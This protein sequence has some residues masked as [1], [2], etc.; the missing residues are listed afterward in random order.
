MF[1]YQSFETVYDV[2]Y[3]NDKPRWFHQG[4]EHWKGT[5]YTPIPSHK[6]TNSTRTRREPV[7]G[8]PVKWIIF[9][10]KFNNWHTKSTGAEDYLNKRNQ[11]YFTS[12]PPEKNWTYQLVQILHKK[13]RKS[14][15]KFYFA[16]TEQLSF[17]INQTNKLSQDPISM[18]TI[19]SKVTKGACYSPYFVKHNWAS[20]RQN[21]IE[22]KLILWNGS[23]MKIRSK[24]HVHAPM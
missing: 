22:H 15:Y 5:N 14:W 9:L 1:V 3:F 17:T 19:L 10:T 20:L 6:S 12:N 24:E 2:H 18:L 7:S 23:S 8:W 16:W 21:Q 11:A 4:E 13:K